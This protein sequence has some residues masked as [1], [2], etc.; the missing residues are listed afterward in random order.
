MIRVEGVR[1]EFGK[2]NSRSGQ[3]QLEIED[4]MFIA[5]LGPSGCGQIDN[6]KLYC[7]SS[8]ADIR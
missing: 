5:L 6:I 8:G 3:H 7:R 2:R 1:K 4:S